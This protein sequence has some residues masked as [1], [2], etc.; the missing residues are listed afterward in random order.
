LINKRK[1]DFVKFHSGYKLPGIDRAKL[2]NPGPTKVLQTIGNFGSDSKGKESQITNSSLLQQDPD[3]V[4]T[5]D[6]RS[7]TTDILSKIDILPSLFF[8]LTINP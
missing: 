3:N 4:L 5:Q 8:Q 2:W 7:S 6:H 1:E